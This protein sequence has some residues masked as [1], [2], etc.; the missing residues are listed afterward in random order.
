[1]GRA[2]GSRVRSAA[3]GNMLE[4]R[5]MATFLYLRKVCRFKCLAEALV[6]LKL[7]TVILNISA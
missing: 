3:R 2:A 7:L 1:M 6:L 5:P 4:Y